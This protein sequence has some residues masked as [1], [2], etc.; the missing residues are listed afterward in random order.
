MA[1]TLAVAAWMIVWWVTEALPVS[2][3]ALLPIILFPLTSVFAIKE[4][5]AI[6][7]H[8]VIFLFLGGF[9][10]GRAFEKHQLHHKVALALIRAS[11][12]RPKSVILAFIVATALFSMWVSNTATAVMMLPVAISII[13]LLEIKPG[14]RTGFALALLLAIAYGANIGGMGTLIGSPP[15]LILVGHLKELAGIEIDFTDWLQVG[16]PCSLLLLIIAYFYVTRRILGKKAAHWSEWQQKRIATLLQQEES[17]ERKLSPSEKWVIVIFATT[18]FFWIF[19]SPIKQLTGLPINDSIIAI[20]G[21]LL[22]FAIPVEW[23]KGL[24]ILTW[25]DTQKL[26][27][28]ILLLFGGGLCLAKAMEVSGLLEV[29]GQLFTSLN[30]SPFIFL[31]IGTGVA[32]F[33]TELMSNTA[34]TSL[35]VPLLVA[36]ALSMQLSPLYLAMPAALAASCA[37]MM[38]ISTPPNAVVFSSGHLHMHDMIRAGIIMNLLSLATLSL[39]GHFLYRLI[40]N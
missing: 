23:K 15:N 18:V 26:P 17:K 6:Y 21:G 29:I 12:G 14:Q 2:A 5:T 25:E 10:I 37:F 32:L 34:L 19:K 13:E 38:P 39:M 36:F 4:A 28:G 27:W 16:L 33:A 1:A 40:A 24:R 35:F 11:G 22:M 3:T 20:A 30:L 8:P 7:A 31:I 9:M